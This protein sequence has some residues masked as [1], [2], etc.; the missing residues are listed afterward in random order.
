MLALCRRHGVDN[1][2]FAVSALHAWC[3]PAELL[4]LLDSNNSFS[5]TCWGE[6]DVLVCR[7][8]RRLDPARTYVD[9]KWPRWHVSLGIKAV[10]ALSWMHSLHGGE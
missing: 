5:L 1:A 3:R 2:T 8:L 9:I 7:W 10:A 4:R 6:A